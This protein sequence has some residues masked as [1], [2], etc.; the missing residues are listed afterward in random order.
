MYIGTDI[1]DHEHVLDNDKLHAHI[2]H[3]IYI[4]I[5]MEYFKRRLFV[6]L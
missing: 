6:A 1:T 2:M 5:A 4:V 3:I